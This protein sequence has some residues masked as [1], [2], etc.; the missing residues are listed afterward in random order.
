MSVTKNRSQLSSC[1]LSE[2]TND[3]I[4]RKRTDGQT[5]D[6]GYFIGCCL[7]KVEH[8]KWKKYDTHYHHQPNLNT[9]EP[10]PNL[11]ICPSFAVATLTMISLTQMRQ[12]NGCG[13][14]C[15]GTMLIF[16]VWTLEWSP[17]SIKTPTMSIGSIHP[18][19]D[20][21]AQRQDKVNPP[22]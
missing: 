17:A 4:F 11:P 18:K 9:N 20:H 21:Q 1:T 10:P 7:N 13:S 2:K 8:P 16:L 15:I 12:S 22:C 14:V 6:G 19:W 5:E 3:L